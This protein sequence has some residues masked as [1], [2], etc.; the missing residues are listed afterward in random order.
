[1]KTSREESVIAAGV[2]VIFVAAF[3]VYWPAMHGGFFWDDLLNIDT[4]PLIRSDAG[5]LKIW[6]GQGNA[7][8]YYP[9]TWTTWWLEWR[10]WGRDTTGYHVLNVIL[11]AGAAAMLWRV[12]A[13]FGVPGAFVSAL[14]FAVHPV[15]V[16]SV[17]W[18]SERKNTLSL[19][20]AAASMAL[21]LDARER[22]NRRMYW[23]SV[24]FFALALLAKPSVVMLPA[25]LLIV[26]WWK[27]GRISRADVRATAPMFALSA[28]IAVVTIWFH[29][30]RGMGSFDVRGDG[31][32]ARLA[33][34]GM[35]VW[36][37]LLKLLAPVQLS[38]VY[39]RWEIDAA[40]VRTWLPLAALV[41][42]FVIALYGRRVW[43]RGPLAAL[44]CFVALLLPVLGFVD[45]YFMRFSFVADHWQY[46]ACIA[47]IALAVAAV[48]H[49]L[50]RVSAR[51]SFHF[52]TGSALAVMA[53]A[54]LGLLAWRQAHLYRSAAALWADAVAKSPRA[55][56]ALANYA[57]ELRTAGRV[58]AARAHYLR[59]I[60]ANPD[61]R[62][63]YAMMGQMYERLGNADE[64]IKWYRT[65]VGRPG[66]ATDPRVHLAGV[67]RAQGKYDQAI[68][69]YEQALAAGGDIG[70]VHT[71]LGTLY[72]E[73]GRT[74]EAIEQFR[75]AVRRWPDQP[76]DR[77]VL[78]LALLET[79]QAAE[80]DEH[81]AEARRLLRGDH[82]ALN[83]LGVRLMV[84]RHYPQ[85]ASFFEAVTQIRPDYAQGHN[86]LGKALEGMGRLEEAAARFD[87]A[88]AEQPGFQQARINLDRV[89]AAS[90]SSTTRPASP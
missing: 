3:L 11:H 61:A 72:Y 76:E 63:T 78:S 82:V 50:R 45:V 53:C 35:V 87:R 47:P 33:G 43:G 83:S 14:I 7:Y 21:Y 80:A 73:T 5:L 32:P 88:L 85:A 74:A 60:D 75:A 26:A 40:S 52:A 23:T 59:A 58:E 17:A 2:A 44:A 56:L 77:F 22:S 67:F 54:A 24:C 66:G 48:A 19:F 20:L 15:N 34:A 6:L 64:A 10:A 37:Y 31:F 57:N 38:F 4:N 12:L 29:H 1:M 86:N 28:V 41:L 55:W 90:A 65:G 70:I 16:E 89:R 46:P 51:S 30:T 18:I 39:P 79:G 71:P 49:A 9:L 25:V 27:Q 69:W 8:D 81:L 84:G 36:F 42:A 13:R 62:E 68:H